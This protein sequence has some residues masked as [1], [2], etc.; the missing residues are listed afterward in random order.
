[1]R[2]I[3]QPTAT[4][5]SV[6][7]THQRGVHRVAGE[8][9]LFHDGMIAADDHAA[10]R[11]IADDDFARLAAVIKVRRFAVAHDGNYLLR[12]ENHRR[13]AV[14]AGA[15]QPVAGVEERD[16]N[17]EG[18]QQHGET[19]LDEVQDARAHR[20]AADGFNQRERDV[21]AVEH[22]QRQQVEQRKI[23]VEDDAEPQHAPPAVFVL[24]QIAVN[25]DDHHRAAELLDA[26][27]ALGREQSADSAENLR[28]R[29][30]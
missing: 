22:R 12:R 27:L 13:F 25:A 19:A 29:F 9:G 7:L 30:H 8:H 16:V 28:R 11:R 21:S 17:H 20:P 6:C 4:S 2:T 10:V 24:K 14:G 3:W 5:S 1:M 15:A 23:H 18:D 26:D